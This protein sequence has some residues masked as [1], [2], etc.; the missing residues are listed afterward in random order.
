[1]PSIS[2]IIPETVA[3]I[4][5]VLNDEYLVVSKLNT[6]KKKIEKYFFLDAHYSHSVEEYRG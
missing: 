5:E 1:M 6:F 2:H 4:Y 3:A